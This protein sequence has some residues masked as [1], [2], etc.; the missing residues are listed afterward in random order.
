MS[1]TWTRYPAD[2]GALYKGDA[3]G[4]LVADIHV[5][6][7]RRDWRDGEIVAEAHT[8]ERTGLRALAM[9]AAQR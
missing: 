3:N 6:W 8:I 7:V 4:Q 9:P 1:T 2:L 5:E